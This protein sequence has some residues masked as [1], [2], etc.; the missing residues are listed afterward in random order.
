MTDKT[1]KEI[2]EEAAEEVTQTVQS[3][4]Q[5]EQYYHHDPVQPVWVMSHLKGTHRDCCL[6]YVCD[7]FNPGKENNCPKAQEL[8]EYCVKHNMTTPVFEC[9]SLVP[10]RQ[11]RAEVEVMK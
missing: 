10:N 6:C 9:T 5:L 1:N 11:K 3:F 8:Y 7:K 2:T 4:P